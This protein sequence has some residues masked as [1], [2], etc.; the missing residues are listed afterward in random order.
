MLFLSLFSL[1][2]R[3]IG[4]T[5]NTEKHW[6][7]NKNRFVSVSVVVPGTRTCVI[8]IALSHDSKDARLKAEN[9]L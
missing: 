8:I 9:S 5:L 7:T 2:P 3:S 6:P 1:F 4:R